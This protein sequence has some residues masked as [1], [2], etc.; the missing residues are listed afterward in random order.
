MVFTPTSGDMSGESL[1]MEACCVKLFE[2][3]AKPSISIPD[4]WYKRA[5]EYPYDT[6]YFLGD[7]ANAI[8]QYPQF[9]DIGGNTG[10]VN[11]FTGVDVP[12]L[13]GGIY[14]AQTLLQGNNFACL[15]FQFATQ[16]KPDLLSLLTPVTNALSPVT[17]ALSSLMNALNCPQLEAIDKSQLMQFPGYKRSNV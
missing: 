13:T 5:V 10:T 9:A 11:S 4:N 15:A 7:A 14:N 17:S 1:Q 16:A 6:E 12:D 3:K 2:A 8:S